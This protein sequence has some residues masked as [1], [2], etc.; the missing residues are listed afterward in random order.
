MEFDDQKAL[1]EDYLRWK[2]SFK[3]NDTSPEAFLIWRT[4]EAAFD[5]LEE[6][7]MYIRDVLKDHPADPVATKIKGLLSGG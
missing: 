3:A 4:R 7:N 1:L 2:G 5:K 6:I